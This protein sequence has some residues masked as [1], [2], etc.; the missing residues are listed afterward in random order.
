MAWPRE[1]SPR[2]PVS[3]PSSAAVDINNSRTVKPCSES[4]LIVTSGP[5]RYTAGRTISTDIVT[6]RAAAL[7][8]LLDRTALCLVVIRTVSTLTIT[9]DTPA[10]SVVLRV[11]PLLLAQSATATTTSYEEVPGT[12]G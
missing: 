3:N 7:L 1:K 9:C 11:L 8:V 5:F 6:C 12:D 10:E 2:T 4:R